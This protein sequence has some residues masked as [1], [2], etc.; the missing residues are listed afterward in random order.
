LVERHQVVAAI[1]SRGDKVLLCHR[2]PIRQ[3][4]PDVWDLPGGHV[5]PAEQPETAL[6]RELIE[7]IGIEIG[8]VSQEP[9]LRLDEASTGLGLIVWHVTRWRGVAENRQPEEHDQ[10][11]WFA[12]QELGGLDLA[13]PSY[14]SLLQRLLG[15][16][17]TPCVDA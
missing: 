2:S 5:E 13:H 11:D 3:W 1:L 14:L 6:R 12:E 10:I 8:V 15:A 17:A 9:V 4:Y 7:E 16:G